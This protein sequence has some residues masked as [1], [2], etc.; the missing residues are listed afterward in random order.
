MIAAGAAAVALDLGVAFTSTAQSAP[1]PG[2]AASC[3]SARSHD[4]YAVAQRFILAAVERKDMRKAY[5]LTTPS[6]RHN[7]SCRD[8]VRG[9]VPLPRMA[10]IDWQRSGYKPVAGGNDQLVLRI[11]LAAPNAAL[12][13]S[14]LM[15]LRQQ[16]DGNWRVGFFERDQAAPQNPALAA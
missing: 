14:F 4:P 2:A 11:F 9:R 8:W 7:A 3:P 12:P 5:A 10:Y 1:R 6:L 13:A 15:E 16:S